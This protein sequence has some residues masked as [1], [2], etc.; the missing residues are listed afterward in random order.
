LGWYV[1]RG[2]VIGDGG[3]CEVCGSGEVVGLLGKTSVMGDIGLERAV[4]GVEFE[5][6]RIFIYAGSSGDAFFG[7][8]TG[9]EE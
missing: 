4:C 9:D 6:T 5:W 8:V 2:K 3:G 1:E 7:S